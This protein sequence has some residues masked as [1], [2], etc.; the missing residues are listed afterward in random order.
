MKFALRIAS[1][2]ASFA[3][4]AANPPALKWGNEQ[5]LSVGYL[6]THMAVDNAGNAFLTGGTY[7]TTTACMVTTKHNVADGAIAWKKEACGLYGFGNGLAL[8]S[9]QNI[10]VAGYVGTK[11]RAVKYA[12]AT[13][14]VIWEQEFTRDAIAIGYAVTVLPN[15]DVIVVGGSSGTNS[16]HPRVLRLKGSD[17]SILWESTF[18]VSP[19]D[20]NYGA[21]ET[22]PD[23]STVVMARSF[24]GNTYRWSIM[25]FRPDGTTMW[26]KQIMNG[27][28]Q[29]TSIALDANGD[30]YAGGVLN[31]LQPGFTDL[32]VFKLAAA[33]GD[34]IWTKDYSVSQINDYPTRLKLDGQGALY[35][36][37]GVEAKFFTAKLNAATGAELWQSKFTAAP[38]GDDAGLDIAFDADGGV[39]V[40]GDTFYQVV[41][42]TRTIKYDA[43]TGTRLWN[44]TDDS[45]RLGLGG[46]LIV[47][48]SSI[49]LLSSLGLPGTLTHLMRLDSTQAQADANAH[50]LWYKSPAES[51]AGWGVNF[52]Q[53]GEIMFMTWFT[54]DTDKNPL[55]F[56]ASGAPRVEGN[57]YSGK[58]YRTT[59]P[60]FNS[61]PFSPSQVHL[62]EVGT[63]TFEFDD[64][65][66]GVFHAM[67]NGVRY[68]HPITRQIYAL[69]LPTCSEANGARTTNYQDLWYASPA[70]SEAGWGINF[71]H[72]QDI[73][74]ATWFTYGPDN[75]PLWVVGSDVRRVPGTE[76]F[77][78]KLYRTTGSAY[79]QVFNPAQFS[80]Q[81][82]GS[83]TVT[84][85]GP[86]AGV[87]EYTLNGI[88]QS[89]TITRQDFALPPTV[90]H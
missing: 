90:C 38:F 71:T 19:S 50:G 43:A 88:S 57:L 21:S 51:E 61:V 84:F 30:V 2:L 39:I 64:N 36:T 70:D 49:Y 62:T 60:A 28:G 8:D 77:T 89:K 22:A 20:D 67:I 1:L 81:E 74:F 48:G 7:T 24:V 46:N 52:A 73:I 13:G 14:N 26:T 9:Q 37:G 18:N 47:R 32:Y 5:V 25:K 75:K 56:V 72:Q 33:T 16:R 66:K 15:D 31:V 27:P 23:G 87:F 68:T 11:I 82:A 4:C 85:T 41:Q 55:W 10:V 80:I 40:T 45:T 65:A 69:P 44:R 76:K 78:G 34:T 63:S 53:Q 79:N 42:Q 3:A 17:G 83:M 86:S 35:V 54:Y 12:N 58:L 59:G 29:P 6:G